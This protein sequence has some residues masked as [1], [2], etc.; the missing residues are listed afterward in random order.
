MSSL[1]LQMLLIIRTEVGSE[2]K[3][4]FPCI[5]VELEAKMSRITMGHL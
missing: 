3:R 4:K 2:A 1:K 5:H